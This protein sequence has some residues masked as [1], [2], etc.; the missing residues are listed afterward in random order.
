VSL[1]GNQYDAVIA[2]MSLHHVMNLK[3][4]LGEVN[5]SLRPDGLLFIKDYI[6]PNRFQFSGRELEAMNSLISLLPL[7]YRKVQ[8]SV[9]AVNSAAAG[10]ANGRTGSNPVRRV[11]AKVRS[12]T[13]LPAIKR[14]SI[15]WLD[16]KR[17]GNSHWRPYRRVSSAEM[18]IADPS[19]AVRAG[20]II[21]LV[22]RSFSIVE[23]KY[24]GGT[25]LQFGLHKIVRNF[26][27][28]TEDTERILEMMVQVED[29]LIR[30][31]D[32]TPHFA[33]VVARKR[34]WS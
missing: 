18:K 33:F 9:E 27:D 8:S 4:L 29:T 26:L 25:L 15:E 24:Y 22:D 32:L 11:A 3:H 31:G 16:E 1:D 17:Y 12:G 10:N 30:F 20:E 34:S 23:K 19:E 13:L 7:R 5:R 21:P 28:E 2:N 6:G 14:K